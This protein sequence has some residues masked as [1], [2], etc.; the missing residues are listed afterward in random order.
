MAIVEGP[1]IAVGYPYRL[2]VSLSDPDG[3]T[4]AALFPSGS[5]LRAT[6]R[7]TRT[8]TASVGD[9]TTGN[10][11]LVRVSDSEIDIVMTAALT[12]ALTAGGKAHL[13]IARTDPAPDEYVGVYLAIPVH[14]PVTRP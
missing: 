1:P 9:L 3:G 12:G 8:D 6:V 13:D 2:R 4:A 14:Q 5:E 7:K 11:G 10:G